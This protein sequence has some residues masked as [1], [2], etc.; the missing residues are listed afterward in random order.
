MKDGMRNSLPT[1]HFGIEGGR[2]FVVGMYA[3]L[4]HQ[5][6]AG[7]KNLDYA[8]TPGGVLRSSTR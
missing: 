1:V 8:G 4:E 7:S 5:K 3:P 6:G 2:V